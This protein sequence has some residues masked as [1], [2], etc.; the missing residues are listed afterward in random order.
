[1]DD[2]L[3]IVTTF[4]HNIIVYNIPLLY[5]TVGE[6]TIEKS[7]SLNLGVEGTMAVGAIFG[8]ILGCYANSM[9]VGVLVAF[10]T[11]AL[12]GLIFAVLTVTFQANQNIT[13]LTI[14]TF[15]LGVF[16]FVGNG[17]KAVSWPAMNNYSNIQNGFADLAIPGLSNIPVLGEVL[18]DHNVLVYLGVVIALVM[19]WYLKYTR[20]GLRLR[21]VGEN[22]AAADSV[23]I[24]VRR[25]KY[26]HIMLGSG[27]MGIGGY[28]M[29]LNM[30]GSLSSSCWINGY[31]WIAVALVIFANWSPAFAMVGT[32]V[33]GFFNTLRVSG[34]S[35]AM[36]L[37]GVPSQLYQALPFLITALVL[38]ATS[39][40]KSK[41]SGQP[42]ALGLNY[43]REER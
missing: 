14:T 12:C 31:G 9:V 40:K 22:P 2:K 11:A 30:N 21:A 41:N 16:F 20:T 38:I 32:V 3:N 7:G 23:G 39:V 5:G 10:L 26:L 8:Y 24:N 13:G 6:I 28:Y 34:P 4:L 17:V 19:W 27:I 1:M 36:A 43:F 35:L 29:G 25:Y 15:G 18:F 37:A 33:F 42:A